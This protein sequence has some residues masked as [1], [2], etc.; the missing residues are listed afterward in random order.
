MALHYDGEVKITKVANM[1]PMGNNGY[2]VTC[3]ETNEAVLIDT[4]GEPEKLL[5]VIGDEK[6]QAILIT[7]NHRDHL[8][9]FDEITG[10]VNAPVGIAPAD[11]HA[12]PKAPDLD[13]TDGRIIKFGNQELEVLNTPGHTDGASCFRVGKHL[14][15]GD[16]L[17]PGG[18]G[19]SR[20]P[21]AFAQLLNS[22]STKLMALSD[23][24]A[25][26]PGHGDD[27]T[28]GEARRR[29]TDFQSR[30]HPANL[31]GDV[32]WLKS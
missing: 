3:P 4:P 13:L 12:L 14:F 26:Y 6:I 9:G 1:S 21:E 29:Y 20:S 24:T 23:D 28:I 18:P 2:L 32:D 8:A 10:K 22:V 30:S 7:H 19:K 5:G 17:F 16:T 27:T 31:C 11:A 25:V 15:S